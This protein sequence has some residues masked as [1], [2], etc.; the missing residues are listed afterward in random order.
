MIGLD[1]M[2]G[3]VGADIVDQRFWKAHQAPVE[4][5]GGVRGTRP[6]ATLLVAHDDLAHR[7]SEPGG[8]GLDLGRHQRLALTL[9]EALQ[10]LGEG[11]G[12]QLTVKMGIMLEDEPVALTPD[13]RPHALAAQIE[14]QLTAEPGQAGPAFQDQFRCDRA[15]R[16]VVELGQDPAGFG[17][18]GAPD[19]PL[20]GPARRGNGQT[21]TRDGETDR[22][23]RRASQGE[24]N[25]PP[26]QLDRILTH[27]AESGI[28]PSTPK[29]RIR[30]SC[31]MTASSVIRE[32]SSSHQSSK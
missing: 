18:Q 21:V 27:A 11:P 19:L 5:D 24:G 2:G 10:G 30:Q 15:G 12:A 3:L 14:G 1:Q 7:S 17:D 25:R 22:P 32:R 8:I 20:A 4:T 31:S 29:R 13:G 9:V 16:P 26:V 28:R 6:P 23:A